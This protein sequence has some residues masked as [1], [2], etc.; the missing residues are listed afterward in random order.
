VQIKELGSD[1]AEGLMQVKMAQLEGENREVQAEGE[2]L[3]SRRM[4]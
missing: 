2:M 4:K 1:V 3:I